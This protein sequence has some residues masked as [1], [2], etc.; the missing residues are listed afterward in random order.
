MHGRQAAQQLFTQ[1]LGFGTSCLA[2]GQNSPGETR[3][4]T[5]CCYFG[6]FCDMLMFMFVFDLAV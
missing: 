6:E 4:L 1:I 3:G 2:M 5:Q